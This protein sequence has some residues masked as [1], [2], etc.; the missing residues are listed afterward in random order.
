MRTVISVLILSLSKDERR[1]DHSKA[2]ERHRPK[3]V[4]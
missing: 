3:S 2:R 1:H 4:L